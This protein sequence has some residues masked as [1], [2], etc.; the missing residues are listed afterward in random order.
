MQEKELVQLAN[1][2]LLPWG[3]DIAIAVAILL[4]GILAAGLVRTLLR[5]AMKRSS[6][7]EVLTRFI[8]S[9]VHKL[10]LAFVVIAAL[11]RLGV[12]TTS[13]VAVL[14]A[15]G[16][17]IGLALKDSLQNFASGVMLVLFRPFKAGDYIEAAGTAGIVEEISIF[18]TTLRTGDNRQIVV[19]NSGIYSGNITNYSARDTRRIDMVFG[20]GYDSDLRKAKSLINDILAADERILP[21]PEPLVAVAALADS[22]VNLNVRPW[23]KSSDYWPVLYDLNERIKLAFDDN[24]IVIPYPQMDIH[25]QNVSAGD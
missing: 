5:G 8:V 7:D 1:E 17:A 21:D 19:P 3:V 6:M 25:L 14:G 18:N 10:L 22:S 20:I 13:L 12:N 4:V 2:Y 9:I 16:L 11:D 23:V 15:A 24:D